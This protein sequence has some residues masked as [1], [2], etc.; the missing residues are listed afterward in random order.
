VPGRRQKEIWDAQAAWN[1]PFETIGVMDE[2]RRF[3]ESKVDDLNTQIFETSLNELLSRVD[4]LKP[5]DKAWRDTH[6][7]KSAQFPPPN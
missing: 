7:E 6:P 3:V 4:Y 2:M 1:K 5:F